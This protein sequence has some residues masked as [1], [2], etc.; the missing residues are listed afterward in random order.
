MAD[1]QSGWGCLGATLMLVVL[2]MTACGGLITALRIGFASGDPLVTYL[3][4]KGKISPE[5]ARELRV[6]LPDA[7]NV[8]LNLASELAAI[9]RNKGTRTDNLI[10]WQNAEKQWLAIVD[11]GHFKLDPQIQEIANLINSI[12]EEAIA[13]YGGG[14]GGGTVGLMARKAGSAA[15]SDAHSA[16][17]SDK[18]IEASLKA[19]LQEL[20]K[21]L[22]P[23]KE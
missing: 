8:G 23:P 15:N 4:A 11:R 5:T 1:R 16:A 6:D 18:E 12:F 9:K 3:E 7:R 14:S 19:K 10:A 22:E 17:R 20:K 21:K 13:A 2:L